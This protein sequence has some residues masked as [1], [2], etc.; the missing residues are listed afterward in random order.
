MFQFQLSTVGKH[1]CELMTTDFAINS[2]PLPMK[3]R[4]IRPNDHRRCV[5]TFANRVEGFWLF[6]FSPRHNHL[7]ILEGNTIAEL[8]GNTFRLS[9]QKIR[10]EVSS[11]HP[12]FLIGLIALYITS[13]TKVYVNK[14]WQVYI[15]VQPLLSLITENQQIKKDSKN[16]PKKKVAMFSRTRRVHNL[17]TNDRAWRWQESVEPESALERQFEQN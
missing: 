1:R 13:N 12:P 6:H 17:S 2:R 10:G 15:R 11:T 3:W 14:I 8:R 5:F 16:T 7:W 9:N 4:L